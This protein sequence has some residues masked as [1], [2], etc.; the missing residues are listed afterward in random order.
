MFLLEVNSFLLWIGAADGQNDTEAIMWSMLLGWWINGFCFHHQKFQ[1]E[2]FH[3]QDSHSCQLLDRQVG[4]NTF[5][6]QESLLPDRDDGGR[7][8]NCSLPMKVV[9]GTQL[10]DTLF[11][12]HCL[13]W[14]VLT[15]IC[16]LRMFGGVANGSGEAFTPGMAEN[17]NG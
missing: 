17:Y 3:H 2:P 7:T 13:F 16:H 6:I 11:P 9:S 5:V 10:A 8:G 4:R 15:I 12:L 1:A 14:V